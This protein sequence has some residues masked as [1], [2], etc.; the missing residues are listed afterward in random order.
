MPID[1]ITALPDP[2]SQADPQEFDSRA[3][4]FLAGIAATVPALDPTAAAINSAAASANAQALHA[5]LAAAAAEASAAAAAVQTTAAAYAA[6]TTYGLGAVCLGSDGRVYRS[7]SAGNVG[8]Q[9][10]GDIDGWWTPLNPDPLLTAAML[11]GAGLVPGWDFQAQDPAGTYPP[12]DSLEPAALVWSR[13]TERYRALITWG[14]SG[15]DAAAPTAAQM[16]YS[17]NSGGS[18]AALGDAISLGNASDGALV[19]AAWDG[20]TATPPTGSAWWEYST[21]AAGDVFA[22]YDAMG[23]ASAAAALQDVSGNANHLTDDGT[24]PISGGWATGSGW[25][26]LSGY[27]VSGARVPIAVGT[28]G[29]ADCTPADL[30]LM[31]AYSHPTGSAVYSLGG[32]YEASVTRRIILKAD[33]EGGTMEFAAGT[34][35]ALTGQ[36]SFGVL[37]KSGLSA[38]HNTTSIG[39]RSDTTWSANFAIAIGSYIANDGALAGPRYATIKGVAIYTRELTTTEREAITAQMLAEFFP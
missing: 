39:T 9:P 25:E 35:T 4:A 27:A 33:E 30:T 20:T 32:G 34:L 13:G 17:T 12:T 31:I 28:A 10:V 3:D 16:Q 18:Y 24:A 5:A 29:G 6:G 8:H 1:P 23:A 19:S 22:A 11:A 36:A 37:V 15:G 38:W 26:A 14:T 21:V 7:Q 2:P